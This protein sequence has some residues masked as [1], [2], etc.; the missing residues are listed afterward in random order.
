TLNYNTRSPH[1]EANDVGFEPEWDLHRV[2]LDLGYRQQRPF[3]AFQSAAAK[4]SASGTVAWDGLLQDAWI[5]PGINATTRG[6]RYHSF[7]TGWRPSGTYTARETADGARYERADWLRADGS[8]A[9]DSRAWL[10]GS[11]S[12]GGGLSPRRSTWGLWTSLA[13]AVRPSS[14]LEISASVDA[15]MTEDQLRVHHCDDAGGGT[16]SRASTSRDYVLAD[17]DHGSL[18]LTGRVGWALSTTLSLQGWAQLFAARGRWARY[19]AITGQIGPEPFLDR[20]E[21]EPTDYAGDDDG[22]GIKDDDFA[23]SALHANLVLRWELRPG[24]ALTAVYTRAQEADRVLAGERPQLGYAGL[25]H[26]ATEEIFLLK[27]GWYWA[28]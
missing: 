14:P 12:A 9:S 11:A 5:G 10:R 4:M 2:S 6:F 27:L 25:A 8:V 28:R 20:A 16:C 13:L 1:F 22:D 17:L 19:R 18:S 15:D 7:S 21:L 23:W 3:G 24:A 26:A